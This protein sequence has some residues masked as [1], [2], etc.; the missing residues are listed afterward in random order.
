MTIST[1]ISD[2]LYRYQCVILPGFGAFLTQNLS[3]RIDKETNT[4]YPP[5]KIIS[6]NKQLQT[7][8]G[9]LANYVASVENCSYETALRRLRNFS[10]ETLTRLE[11]GE[12]VIFK[13]VGEFSQIE[14]GVIQ[15]FPKANQNFSTASFG[16]SSFVSENIHRE[17]VEKVAKTEK[18]F[19]KKPV[20][21]SSSEKTQVRERKPYLKYAAIAV[22]ALLAGG[23]GGMSVYENQIEK[24]NLAAR[25]HASHRV[26]NH[27]QEATFVIKNPLPAINL[28]VAKQTGDYHLVAGAFREEENADK[29]LEEL[30]NQGYF[31]RKLT[32]RYGLHQILY[33]SFEDRKEALEVL[34]KIQHTENENAWL[35]VQKIDSSI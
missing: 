14:K 30:R 3:A 26:E 9:L 21:L 4:F 6:F 2:L 33:Q 11:K 19:E 24:Q 20:V 27:I 7:N 34:R 25:Q 12:S 35:L 8:D 23:F 16:L 32:S 31:P 15:F 10:T 22:V 17:I 5:S 1:Y 28:N 29:K 13:N 18:Q